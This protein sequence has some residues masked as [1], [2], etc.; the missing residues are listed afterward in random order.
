MIGMRRDA[1]NGFCA[2]YDLLVKRVVDRSR[3]NATHLHFEPKW[4]AHA[5][6]EMATNRHLALLIERSL[7][8]ARRSP[9]ASAIPTAAAAIAFAALSGLGKQ[10]AVAFGCALAAVRR[11]AKAAEVALTR[12]IQSAATVSSLAR[13]CPP[14]TFFG[15]R[16]IAPDLG[17]LLVEEFVREPKLVV[18][19]G[20]G[21]STILIAAML[22]ARTGGRIL[23]VEH[24]PRWADAVRS[25]LAAGGLEEHAE[26]VDAPLVAQRFGVH[27][28][29]WYQAAALADRVPVPI[30]LLLVDGPPSTGSRAR[31]PA[32]EV[33]GRHLSSDATILLDDGRRRSERVTAFRWARDHN[34]DLYWIDTTKGTWKLTQRSAPPPRALLRAV[35]AV[36]RAIHPRPPGF[37]LGTIRR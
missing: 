2:P 1:E 13:L 17:R 18:E 19:C 36:R 6:S 9:T 20:S 5:L 22:K 12:E 26:V 15:G 11:A 25:R 28:V 14:G 7:D 33:F 35:L 21:S 34:L 8:E 31:W 3:R 24:D 27:E 29:V 30:D 16:A 23:A 4:K 37:G 32:L 10:R